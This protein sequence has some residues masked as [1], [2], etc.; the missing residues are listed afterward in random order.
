MLNHGAKIAS[1]TQ[2]QTDA[3]WWAWTRVLEASQIPH[4]LINGCVIF[5]LAGRHT[6]YLA[7][8][9]IEYKLHL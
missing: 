1:E 5:I 7:H 2:L 4:Y 3:S 9:D 8:L 6:V